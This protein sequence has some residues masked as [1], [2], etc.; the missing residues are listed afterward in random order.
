MLASRWPWY[1]S[2]ATS[3]FLVSVLAAPLC[4]PGAWVKST[5]CTYRIEGGYWLYDEGWGFTPEGFQGPSYSLAFW[6]VW[7][8]VVLPYLVWLIVLWILFFLLGIA[9][10][11]GGY[12]RCARQAA[13]IAAGFPLVYL[14]IWCIAVS[15]FVLNV[16][17]YVKLTTPELVFPLASSWE[18]WLIAYV[19]PGM[20]VIFGLV[21]LFIGIFN[22]IRNLRVLNRPETD[23]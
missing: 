13:Q 14:T 16:V 9:R 18:I 17:G 11:A 10:A 4:L 21:L 20:F 8:N 22:G 23:S 7:R 1:R 5:I 12:L 19:I 3:F 6:M 2:V 15:M